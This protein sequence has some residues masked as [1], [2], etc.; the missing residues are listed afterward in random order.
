MDA[1][2]TLVLRLFNLRFLQVEISMISTDLNLRCRNNL[3]L[4]FNEK[5]MV[6]GQH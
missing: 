2:A 1:R 3:C 6:S 4:Y 5:A